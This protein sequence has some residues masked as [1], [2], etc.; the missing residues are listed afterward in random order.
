MGIAEKESLLEQFQWF[1]S[2]PELSFQE[3]ETTKKI[4]EIL[5]EHGIEVLPLPLQTGLVAVVRG[6]KPGAV[7]ALRGDIDALP[8]EE[9]SAVPYRSLNRGCMHACGHD[10]HTTAVL[11]AAIALHN[12]REQLAGTVK[13][14]F[15]P[16][17]EVATGALKI[18]EQPVLDDVAAIFGV[19]AVVNV[20]VGTAA[21]SAGSVTAAV[22][23]FQ[24]TVHGRGCHAAEPYKGVDPIVIASQLV[25]ALQSVVSRNVAPLQAG[26]VSVTQIHGGTAWNIIPPSVELEGTVRTLNRNERELIPKRM[27]ELAKGISSAFGGHADFTWIPGPP[28]TDNDPKWA[29]FAQM[30]AKEQGLAVIPSQLTMGGEDFSYFQQIVPGAYIQMGIGESEPLH[31]PAFQLDTDV[32][33]KTA[34]YFAALAEKALQQ[35]AE[36]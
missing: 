10:F 11:G 17:E 27:E 26:L 8:I 5:Q 1:H 12:R 29:A 35:L 3:V 34:D 33:Q 22:D 2:H 16:G 9:E 14:I 20:P 21:V 19:H 6:A 7:V 23:R 18:T 32:I 24:I 15:Q 31:H 13:V 36:E 25:T 28:A 30:V 4:K